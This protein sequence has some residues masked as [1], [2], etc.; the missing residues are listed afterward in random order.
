MDDEYMAE[1]NCP[2]CNEEWD[3]YECQVCGF[4]DMLPQDE[5]ETPEGNIVRCSEDQAFDRGYLYKCPSCGATITWWEM[6]DH[7]MCIEC[8]HRKNK[9]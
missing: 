6:E 2:H 8:W 4:S 9:D 1:L 3:G 5:Y 7:G